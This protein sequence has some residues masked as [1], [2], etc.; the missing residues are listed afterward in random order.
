MKFYRKLAATYDLKSKL[1]PGI[2]VL[3]GGAGAAQIMLLLASPIITRLYSPADFGV[4]AL[5]GS[6]LAVTGSFVTG[7]LELSILDRKSLFGAFLSFSF[8]MF[9]GLF[10]TSFMALSLILFWD[11]I[12]QLVALKFDV[13]IL[14]YFV[15]AIFALCL[16][17]GT[18]HLATRLQYYQLLGSS[19]IVQALFNIIALC[20]LAM[21]GFSTVGL[22]AGHIVG[23]FA[24]CLFLFVCLRLKLNSRLIK[25]FSTAYAKLFIHKYYK[26]PV[27][28]SPADA[29]SSMGLLAPPLI[30]G[31]T[32]GAEIAGFYA[33]SQR[34]V[35]G[36]ISMLAQAIG[37]VYL[38][39]VADLIRRD[40][41]QIRN[42]FGQLVI[43][44][45]VLGL[46]LVLPLSFAARS[47]FPSIFGDEWYVAGQYCVL[48]IPMFY[49]Q[50][51][52][53]PIS[54]TLALIGKQ[55]TMMFLDCLRLI[56]LG[57]S[58]LFIRIL[59]LSAFEAVLMISIFNTISYTFYLITISY[60]VFAK[61]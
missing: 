26:Y 5:F 61:D 56:L 51:T 13:Y 60:V 48:L 50:F 3:L 22:I 49:F 39:N 10:V 6:F 19:K 44:L 7:R 21:F 12:I 1:L 57:L 20:F 15:V 24:A 37:Q 41:S 16:L 14:W 11:Q 17:Q 45:G 29:M 8:S 4:F 23:I 31:V 32:F 47:L 34:V 58:Y 42:L 25:F 40:R 18:T 52:V 55:K 53:S 54:N 59:D 9:Y 35:G 46:L 38:G 33:L 43:C 2:F 30:L 28:V 36:P 27:F